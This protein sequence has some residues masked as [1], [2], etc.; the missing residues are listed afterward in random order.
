MLVL[1]PARFDAIL[2]LAFVA[3]AAVGKVQGMEALAT[4]AARGTADELRALA[5][6]HHARLTE[7]ALRYAIERTPSY[8]ARYGVPAEAVTARGPQPRA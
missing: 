8:L 7:S 1:D 4:A 3:G 5:E 2:E 6:R